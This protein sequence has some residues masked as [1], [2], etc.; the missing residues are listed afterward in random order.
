MY[1]E[2]KRFDAVEAFYY[3][4]LLSGILLILLGTGIL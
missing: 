3:V 1:K 2:K 4:G